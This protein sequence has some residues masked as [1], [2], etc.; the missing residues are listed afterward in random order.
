MIRLVVLILSYSIAPLLPCDSLSTPTASSILFR[1]H[2][3]ETGTS[4]CWDI[5]NWMSI[6]LHSVDYTL[7][8]FTQHLSL[9]F[10][11]SVLLPLPPSSFFIS[12]ISD[13]AFFHLVLL[14]P[15]NSP[16]ASKRTYGL[17]SFL[18]SISSFLSPF[19][20]SDATWSN[21]IPM[22]RNSFFHF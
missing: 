9:L 2:A 20:S 19:L 15:P 16:Q 14:H 11:I 13:V 1:I 21:K 6:A 3:S 17:S 10:W 18:L 5:F 7:M 8:T 22:T 12:F 4:S